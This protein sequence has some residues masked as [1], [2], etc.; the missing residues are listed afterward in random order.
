MR[1]VELTFS[2]IRRNNSDAEI[3]CL[4]LSPVGLSVLF[5]ISHVSGTPEGVK[6][7]IRLRLKS[8]APGFVASTIVLL[9]SLIGKGPVRLPT[10]LACFGLAALGIVAGLC[11]ESA[12]RP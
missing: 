6:L 5:V 1:A 4:T 11:I 7:G 10:S 9:P 12:D 3:F 2:S 8:S